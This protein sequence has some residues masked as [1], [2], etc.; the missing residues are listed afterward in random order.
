MNISGEILQITSESPWLD[1]AIALDHH[2][3]PHPWSNQAWHDGLKQHHLLFG[4]VENK[5][6]IG[7]ALFHY[8]G[9]EASAHLLKIL[10]IP[11]V[12]GTG[13]AAIFW[14]EILQQLRQL[15]IGQV[16]LEVET[17]NERALKFYQKSGFK[18][19]THKKAFYSD[20]SDAFAM[21]L[22]L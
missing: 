17:Q 16:Y 18:I 4:V 8:T 6:L 3:F 2:Y 20:G 12:R 5:N 19:L 13:V 9:L 14:G 7:L 22:T 10:L 1:G 15:S 21:L 11:D